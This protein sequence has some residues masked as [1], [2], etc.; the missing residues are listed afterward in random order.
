MILS[1]V[2]WTRGSE[3]IDQSE[4]FN[5][6]DSGWELHFWWFHAGLFHQGDDDENSWQK[7][8]CN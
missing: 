3:I 5:R 2:S 8:A 7:L 4:L 1:N 6:I